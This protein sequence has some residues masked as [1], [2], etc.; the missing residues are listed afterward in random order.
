MSLEN[1]ILL[2]YEICGNPFID[3]TTTI[4]MRK[5]CHKML[6]LSHPGKVPSQTQQIHNNMSEDSRYLSPTLISR[7]IGLMFA[8]EPFL[9]DLGRSNLVCKV[10]GTQL[11]K[12]QKNIV[13]I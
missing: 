12:F 9:S 2:L 5:S 11:E 4:F 6:L 8:F 3:G 7:Y 1:Q 10:Y 13:A